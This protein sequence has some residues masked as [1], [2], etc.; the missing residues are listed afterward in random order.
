MGF[1]DTIFGGDGGKSSR[2]SDAAVVER[3]PFGG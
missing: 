1:S 3:D 2:D